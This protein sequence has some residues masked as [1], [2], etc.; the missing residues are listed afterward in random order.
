MPYLLHQPI[1]QWADRQPDHEAVRFSGHGLTYADLARRSNQLARVLRSRGVR[2]GDRVGFYMHK[3][4]HTAVSLYGIMKAGAAY[5][6]LD[7]TAPPARI[8]Y[9]L[10]DCRIRHLIT[11]AK[12][13]PVV[14]ELLDE[15]VE[16]DLVVGAGA[17]RSMPVDTLTWD[18]IETAPD[19]RPDVSLTELDLSYVLYTSGSTGTPKGVAHTHR[20]ALSFAETAVRTYGFRAD[21]RLSNHAPLHFDLSTLDFF[22]TACAGATVVM[23]PEMYTKL[24]ASL[25]QLM[26]DERLTVL[27]VVPLVL[28][29]LLEHG[30]LDRRTLQSLRWVLFGGEPFPP[31]HLRRLMAQWPHAQFCNVYGPTETNGVTYHVVPALEEGPSPNEPDDSP[32]PIG[33]L[34]SNVEALVLG[35]DDTPVPDGE[36]GELAIRA[37]SMMRGYWNQPDLNASAFFQRPAFEHFTD[38]FYRTGDLV[39]RDENE[40]YHFLGR[41][42]RQIK[43]RGYRVELTE[44]EAALLRHPAVQGAAAYAVPG[45]DGTKRIEATVTLVPTD[46]ADPAAASEHASGESP[47]SEASVSEA[48]IRDDAA[49]Y[50]PSYALPE[51]ISVIE[52][53]PRTST[54]KIDRQ[55]L[56]EQTSSPASA[57]SPPG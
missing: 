45:S 10:R 20:S 17:E 47:T 24:P 56:Q 35:P 39:R 18:D 40:V 26:E 57:P 11:D 27:Y 4:L 50:L 22:A 48:S 9:I 51:R 25:S 36:T 16:L 54:G 55:A 32:L 28:T 6:P 14:G 42:D 43:T 5:V 37:P 41:K 52:R 31:K 38:V 49:R 1:D 8:A 3:S 7:P 12:H 21:D 44:V 33:T 29:H 30:A 13:A 53:F 34:Y 15:S 2:R 46:A 19:R 23:I